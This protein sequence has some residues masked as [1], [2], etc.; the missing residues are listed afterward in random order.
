MMMTINDAR[1][2]CLKD[3]ERLIGPCYW[4]RLQ[5]ERKKVV[6]GDQGFDKE[7]SGDNICESIGGG[8]GLGFIIQSL[9]FIK[10]Y[11]KSLASVPS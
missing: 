10:G 1:K 9:L 3:D 4:L 8:L 6:G 2:G 5:Q 7:D 11:E